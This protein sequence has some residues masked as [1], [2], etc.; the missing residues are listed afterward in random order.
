MWRRVFSSEVF[1]ARS[2]RSAHKTTNVQRAHASFFLL[3]FLFYFKVTHSLVGL[4][5]TFAQVVSIIKLQQHHN[6]ATKP[7]T[8]HRQKTNAFYSST[9]RF[10]AI[11]PLLFA[12]TAFAAPEHPAAVANL[13][14]RLAPTGGSTVGGNGTYHHPSSTSASETRPLSSSGASPTSSGPAQQTTGAAGRVEIAGMALGGVLAA[15]LLV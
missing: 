5:R 4:L 14:K 9:M 15:A 2:T 7:T 1:W 12:A 3:R 10:F 8:V 13:A 11:A 6:Q